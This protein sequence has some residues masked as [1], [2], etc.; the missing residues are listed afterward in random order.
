[1]FH[2]NTEFDLEPVPTKR[3]F[4]S[5]FQYQSHIIIIIYY[6]VLCLEHQR[7]PTNSM[8]PKYVVMLLECVGHL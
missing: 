4:I 8:N 5:G 3:Y 7:K 6:Y 2:D 1:M